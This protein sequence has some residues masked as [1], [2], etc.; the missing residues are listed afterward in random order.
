[1]DND[2]RDPIRTG[3][4]AEIARRFAHMHAT[5]AERA[6]PITARPMT[7]ATG[8]VIPIPWYRRQMLPRL[9]AAVV[10]VA[11]GFMLF[12]EQPE[13]DPAM[14]YADIMGKQQMQ[15]DTFLH[16]SNSVLPAMATLPSLYEF[17]VEFDGETYS[18]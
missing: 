14:M 6:P 15:T 2:N 11:I 8:K 5:E 18:N 3:N 16:V 4:D 9:A 13:Q 1:M 7:A 10:L 12:R 17:D